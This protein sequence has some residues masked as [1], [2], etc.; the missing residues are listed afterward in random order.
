LSTG[1]CACQLAFIKLIEVRYD[2]AF[3][4][5]HADSYRVFDFPE[6]LVGSRPQIDDELIFRLEG[7]GDGFPPTRFHG[8]IVKLCASRKTVK[9]NHVAGA[10]NPEEG[11]TDSKLIPGT[12]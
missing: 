10:N 5:L 4:V 6:R 11:R 9:R 2:F 8:G 7:F 12:I 3:G 1:D